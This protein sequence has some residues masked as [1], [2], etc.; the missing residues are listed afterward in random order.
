MKPLSVRRWYT[1]PV[2]F[3]GLHVVGKKLLLHFAW[4]ALRA[5]KSDMSFAKAMKHAA[6]TTMSPQVL[7]KKP[8]TGPGIQ[9]AWAGLEADRAGEMAAAPR[10]KERMHRGM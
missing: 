5:R 10:H 9:L 1:K 7:L 8:E 6:M 2:P 4:A 3:L